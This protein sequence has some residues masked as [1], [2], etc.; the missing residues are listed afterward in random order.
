MVAAIK[1]TRSEN[2]IAVLEKI[3]RGKRLRVREITLDLSPTM[4]LIARTVFPD[5]KRTND[6]FHVHKFF[7][8]AIDDLRI[9]LRWMAR[10]LENTIMADCKR[11]GRE[12]VPFRYANGDTRKQLLV[13][14][15]FI[16]TKHSSFEVDQ[17]SDSQDGITKWSN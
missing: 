13:R 17:G 7:Y 1:G 14:V 3:Q 2:V 11:D 9:N 10:D 8:E 6:R 15:K 12:Y 4:M 5:A 16:L